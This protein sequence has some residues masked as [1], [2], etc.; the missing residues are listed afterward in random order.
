M[1]EGPVHGG[2]CHAWAGGPEFYKKADRASHE[3]QACN[4][5]PTMASD[6]PP[7]CSPA[8]VP[9]LAFSSDGL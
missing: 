3:E 9:V 1:G 4:Q 6:Q 5:H 7:S 2:W 8:W